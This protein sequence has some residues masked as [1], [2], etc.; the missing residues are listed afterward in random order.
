MSVVTSCTAGDLIFWRFETGQPYLRF[1]V[2]NPTHQLPVIYNAN[3][4]RTTTG[5]PLAGVTSQ[6]AMKN[7]NSE[8]TL[9]GRFGKSWK[10]VVILESLLK[11]S[12]CVCRSSSRLLSDVKSEPEQTAVCML[13]L[14]NRSVDVA[15]G[16]LL[17]SLSSGR[18]QVWS[19]HEKIF[20]YITAF[21]AVHVAGDVS[22]WLIDVHFACWSW[23]I[24]SFSPFC[25]SRRFLISA[26]SFRRRSRRT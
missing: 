11:T 17:V 20:C 1:N 8:E 9:G 15:N 5:S 10:K 18:M 7:E 24:H 25:L 13:S 19:H 2:N 4:A 12:V 14:N 22:K 6:K 26:C 23:C 21:N 16:T 3:V